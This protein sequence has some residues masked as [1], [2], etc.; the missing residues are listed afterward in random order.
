MDLQM[1]NRLE[2]T[3]RRKGFRRFFVVLNF[4]LLTTR[5]CNINCR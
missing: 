2:N 4:E 3:K 5:P 1:E